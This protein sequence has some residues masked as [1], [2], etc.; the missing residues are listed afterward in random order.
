MAD[1]VS[2]SIGYTMNMGDFNSM[3]FDFGVETD[4]R[5]GETAKAAMERAREF[6]SATLSTEIQKASS[7][8]GS[9]GQAVKRGG[10]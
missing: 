6:V 5:E 3:R 8:R 9:L 10:Q 7:S 1:R 4:V 2:A